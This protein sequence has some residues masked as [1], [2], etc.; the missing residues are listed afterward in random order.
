MWNK[1][2]NFLVIKGLFPTN[3]LFQISKITIVWTGQ[4]AKNNK[5]KFIEMVIQEFPSWR[6]G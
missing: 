3:K 5:I 1:E 4:K 2:Q 6:S